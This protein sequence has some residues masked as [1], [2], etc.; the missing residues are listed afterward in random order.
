[1]TT[2]NFDKVAPYYDQ[3]ARLIFSDSIKKAQL[4]FLDQIKPKS[5]V[6]ILGGGTGWIIQE[7][8][9][10]EKD[11]EV[12]YVEKSSKML[13]IARSRLNS[14]DLQKTH[15][16]YNS[17]EDWNTEINFDIVI[18]NFFLD[19]FSE[20]KLQQ[21][22]IPKLKYLLKSGGKLLVADFQNK[23]NLLWQK[24]LL[25]MMHVFFGKVSKLESKQLTNFGDVLGRA[26]F[27]LEIERDFHRSMIFS[28]VYGL[29]S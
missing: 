15:F 22:I 16:I 29:K 1:M 4:E 7:L 18:C 13:E 25:W 23:K 20:V 24:L 11:V 12:F 2:N 3:L 17:I 21:K 8:M 10:I 19:V 6:L 28:Q 27:D 14:E 26:G 9:A 5:K